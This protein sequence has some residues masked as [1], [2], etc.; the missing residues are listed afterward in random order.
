MQARRP[1][2]RLAPFVGIVRHHRMRMRGRTILVTGGTSGIGRAL[3]AKLLARGNTVLVTGRS[4]ARLAEVRA[5]SPGVHTFVCDQSDPAAVARLCAEATAAHPEL[6]VLVNNAGVG[7]KRDLT[8][9]AT[10]PDELAQEIRTN[11][12]GP[13]QLTAGLL[14]HLLRRPEAMVVNVTSGLAFT[15]LPLKPVYCATKAAMHSY[16]QSLRVQLGSTSVKV[17]ELAPPAVKTEFNRGQEEMNHGPQMSADALADAAL[18]GLEGG[19]EEILPGLARV[20][21]N[22]ARLR[23]GA[24]LRAAEAERM[25]AARLAAAG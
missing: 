2:F 6:D 21:R 23:P 22:M 20:L 17:V 9:P 7:L 3:A 16:T 1:T 11:L 15:P 25:V 13:V 5:A 19:R 8:D 4:E 24:T 10:A 12:I 14:P 18:Q